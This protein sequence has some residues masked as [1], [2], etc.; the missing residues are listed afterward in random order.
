MG[1]HFVLIFIQHELQI[2]LNWLQLQLKLQI[3]VCKPIL[4]THLVKN[5]TPSVMITDSVNAIC[6]NYR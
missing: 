4:T 1:L 6:N 5:A 2:S 3:G